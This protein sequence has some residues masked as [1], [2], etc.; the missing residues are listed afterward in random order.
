MVKN[1]SR[2]RI[3]SIALALVVIAGGA[4]RAIA[5]DFWVNVEAGHS[6]RPEAKGQ[7]VL[8]VQP[9]GCHEPEN[10]VITATAEGLVHGQ[11]RSLP[12][13]LT[14]ISR[15]VYEISREWPSEGA[16]VVAI[17]AE[18]RGLPRAA[19]V[20]L[21]PGG[22]IPDQLAISKDGSGL[23]SVQSF[24]RK[25]ASDDIDSALRAMVGKRDER[26]G[27]RAAK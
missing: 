21:G 2:L 12:L 17:N 26:V 15:G 22:N 9:A 20:K 6:S 24:R 18:Y 19:I 8:V 7:S 27:T 4:A 1:T 5:G 16:W 14:S 10:A 13:K 11:R 23:A 3:S 25:V